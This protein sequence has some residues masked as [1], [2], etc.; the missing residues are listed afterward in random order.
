VPNFFKKEELE[1]VLKGIEGLVDILA[2]KLH[3]AGKIKG[4][5]IKYNSNFKSYLRI[6]FQ[7][8]TAVTSEFCRVMNSTLNLKYCNHLLHSD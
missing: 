5:G 8:F 7:F 4:A 1:P 6:A 3:Q 2:E